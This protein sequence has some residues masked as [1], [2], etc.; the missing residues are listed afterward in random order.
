[1][2]WG[3]LARSV[4]PVGPFVSPG[5]F[6]AW[7][8][9]LGLGGPLPLVRFPGH[10]GPSQSRWRRRNNMILGVL[11][12]FLFSVISVLF[13][14]ITFFFTKTIYCIIQRQHECFYELVFFC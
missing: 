12:H 11:A 3:R 7:V 5:S 2:R 6:E 4:G 10:V 1:M 9:P 14:I 8:S 13:V